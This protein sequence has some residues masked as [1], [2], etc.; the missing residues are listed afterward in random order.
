MKKKSL[1]FL[2]VAVFGAAMLASAWADDPS[3]PSRPLPISGERESDDVYIAKECRD[4]NVIMI[5]L[6]NVSAEHM[7]LYGYERITTPRLDAWAKDAIVF[8]NAFTQ[9]SWTLPVGVSLFTSLYPYAHGV[10]DRYENNVLSENIKTL[11]EVMKENG[12]ATAAFTGGLDYSKTFGHMRGFDTVVEEG[13]EVNWP[14]DFAGLSTAFLRAHEWLEKQ[15]ENK[16]FLFVH[17]YD[18]HCPFIPPEK[19]AGVFSE[20]KNAVTI[21][22]SQCLRGYRN[23]ETE[24]YEA[25]YFKNG[26]HKTALTKND[27]RY[28]EDSYDEEILS[29]DDL[30]MKFLQNIEKRVLDKTVIIVFSDHGEMFAKHGR[31]GRAGAIRGTLY[32]DVLHIPLI[33]KIPEQKGRR[34]DALVEVVDIMPTL[35][36]ML[37]IRAETIAQG[38]DLLSLRKEDRDNFVFSGSEFNVGL[39]SSAYRQKSVNEAVRNYDWKLIHE[40]KLS[41]SGA[42]EEETFELYDI[43]N[44]KD[45]LHNVIDDRADIAAELKSVLSEW[46][47]KSKKIRNEGVTKHVPDGLSEEARKRGYW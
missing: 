11:P 8:E 46:A 20:N 3:A 18:T 35:L 33:M 36:N 47:A 1:F 5:S 38:K 32:D 6:S 43:K 7:S 10:T 24:T 21:D 31:F 40:V 19:F 16:F 28:L 44:D 17:G 41:D 45:E 9:S 26:Q 39:V 25:Y 23:N 12:Y 22:T 13:E 30:T 34:M 14:T 4:C 29:A 2:I 27:I 37:N 15:K 42:V